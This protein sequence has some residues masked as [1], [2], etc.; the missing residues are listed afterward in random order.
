MHGS[1][2]SD[3]LD[4][5]V[6]VNDGGVPGITAVVFDKTGTELFLHSAGTR[7]LSASASSPA[8]EP[9]TPEHV[10]WIASCTKMVTALCVMQLVERGRLALDDADQLEALCPE[11]RDVQVLRDGDGVLEPKRSRITLR[12]LLTHTAGF[13]YTLASEKLRDHGL[14]VGIDEFSG[15]AGAVNTPLIFHPGEGWEYGVGVDWAGIALERLTGVSLNVY[16]QTHI[17]EPLGLE[18]VNMIPTPSM[19]ANLAYMNQR[20][21]QGK[22]HP[23]NHFY[24]QPLVIETEEEKAQLFNSGGAG[25]FAKPQE[26]CRASPPPPPELPGILA[27][28]LNDGACPVTGVRLVSARTVADMFTN[29]I[30]Q[31]PDFGRQGLAAAKPELTNPAPCLDP[32]AAPDAPQG[33]GLSFM[34]SGGAT[35]RSEGTAWW[36][37]MANVFWWA[38]CEN[39]VG[40]MV[41]AQVLPFI[42]A[43]VVGAWT[44]LETAVYAAL[45]EVK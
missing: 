20:D 31:F 1:N 3:I 44:A 7:G 8:A 19:K 33:W 39:G 16:M 38:D 27:V 9:M 10:F 5:A 2:N 45:H 41:C 43:K 6:N 17:C 15:R 37:S 4:A 40:G 22:V 11:L 32:G 26:Y 21:A 30:P 34:L 23:R 29:H 35:G 12:M 36:A 18:S 24:R 42:D 14:P 28:L 25:L 13:G